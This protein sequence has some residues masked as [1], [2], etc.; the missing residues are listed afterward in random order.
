LF[1][2]LRSGMLTRSSGTLSM[3]GKWGERSAGLEE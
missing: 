1:A 2:E 3:T